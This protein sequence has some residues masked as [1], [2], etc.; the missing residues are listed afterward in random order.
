MIWLSSYVLNCFVIKLQ[1][2]STLQKSL[3][4]TDISSNARAYFSNNIQ[5]CY[6]DSSQ[7]VVNNVLGSSTEKNFDDIESDSGR[8][9]NDPKRVAELINAYLC[10]RSGR[11]ESLHIK[12]ACACVRAGPS[13]TALVFLNAYNC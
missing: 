1:V 3:I 11:S 12:T 9:I 13:S 4:F 10:A 6:G 2:K 5:S 8:V 7:Y